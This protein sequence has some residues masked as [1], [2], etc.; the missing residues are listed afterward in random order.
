MRPMYQVLSLAFEYL[1]YQTPE[2]NHCSTHI[3]HALDD[4]NEDD[5]ISNAECMAATEI[6]MRAVH[7]LDSRASYLR[8]AAIT[9]GLL[10]PMHVEY[11]GSTSPK[12]IKFRD[13]WLRQLIEKE[14]KNAIPESPTPRDESTQ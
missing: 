7:E 11:C 4:A 8:T 1:Y 9:A 13:N 5:V 10:P 3:C 14:K 12:Y 6:I 2:R